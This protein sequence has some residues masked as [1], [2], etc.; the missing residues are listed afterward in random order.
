M[1]ECA[2][3]VS[4]WLLFYLR[5]GAKREAS[6]GGW[7]QANVVLQAYRH[8]FKSAQGRSNEAIWNN[9]MVV[10][11]NK[12]HRHRRPCLKRFAKYQNEDGTLFLRATYK[13]GHSMTSISRGS[14]L[15]S[16]KATSVHMFRDQRK[17]TISHWLL[18]YLRY[19]AKDDACKYGWVKIDAVLRAYRHRFRD[20]QGRT[21]EEIWDA[22][23]VVVNQEYHKDRYYR[24][25]LLPPLP[26]FDKKANSYGSRYLRATHSREA[27]MSETRRSPPLP[28]EATAERKFREQKED[29]LLT[30]NCFICLQPAISLEDTPIRTPCCMQ[31]VHYRS[32]GPCI[33]S[34]TP[35]CPVCKKEIFHCPPTRVAGFGLAVEVNDYITESESDYS[36]SYSE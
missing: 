16:S 35:G 25:R 9:I 28:T 30:S 15:L 26:R 20:A 36:M 14:T 7:V 27:S 22:I 29:E 21:D 17:S 24:G 8:R 3:D 23:M 32:L 1:S 4:R 10:V 11:D 6:Q 2:D 19:D 13:D 33:N 31:L 18:K 12:Y 34:A 5:H